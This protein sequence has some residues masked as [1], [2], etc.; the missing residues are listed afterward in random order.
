[1]VVDSDAQTSSLDRRRLV[2]LTTAVA[3]GGV[4]LAAGGPAKAAHDL[5]L[6]P[7]ED[8]MREH[9]LLNR[10][11]LI[12]REAIKRIERGEEVP[13]KEIGAAASVIRSLIHDHHEHVEERYLFSALLRARR[14]TATIH[15]LLGQHAAGR[16]LTTE[17]LQVDNTPKHRFT[18]SARHKLVTTMSDFITMYQPH[19]T[20]EDTEIFPAFRA[21][22]P[23]RQF[24]NLSERLR[25]QEFRRF[26]PMGFARFVSKVID[27]EKS[28]GIHD[29]AQFTPKPSV[30]S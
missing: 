25:E 22:T 11:V 24:V 6:S 10:V 1:M 30:S 15:V 21:I 27:I 4:L 13:H 17:L 28:L 3:G 23:P 26:G 20:R 19:E 14:H 7:P 18:A 5:P 8:L 12:Y 29:L 2:G 16:A 9:G